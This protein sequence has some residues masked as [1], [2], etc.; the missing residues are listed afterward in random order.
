MA[1]LSSRIQENEVKFLSAAEA[2]VECGG[3]N[4]YWNRGCVVIGGQ[5]GMQFH[6]TQTCQLLSTVSPT[7]SLSKN[8]GL[9]VSYTNY[10]TLPQTTS[11]ASLKLHT[12]LSSNHDTTPVS[13]SVNPPTFH[14]RLGGT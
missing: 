14:H 3:V 4:G 2:M 5:V 11:A 9:L 13:I 6:Q 10:L 7:R 8:A 12:N 1:F